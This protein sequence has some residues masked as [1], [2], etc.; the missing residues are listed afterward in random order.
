MELTHR[1]F[2]Y[3]CCH[4]L[5]FASSLGG[6]EAQR[7]TSSVQVDRVPQVTRL[8]FGSCSV[9][10]PFRGTVLLSNQT[11]AAWAIRK[12]DTDCGCLSV[13]ANKPTCAVGQVIQLDVQLAAAN[14][15]A[16]LRRSV[17]IYFEAIDKPLVLN[18]DVSV[19]GPI[20][21]ARTVFDVQSNKQ[22]LEIVGIKTRP[23]I[24]IDRLISG[25][26]G[27][28]VEGEVNQDDDSFRV[29]IQ[30]LHGFGT[31]SDILRVRYEDEK[32]RSLIVE[33]PIELRCVDQIRFLPST[34][35]MQRE[36]GRWVG[37]TRMVLSP[38]SGPIDLKT[39]RCVFA[40][41]DPDLGEGQCE[42]KIQPLSPVLSVVQ[43]TVPDDGQQVMPHFVEI[44]D[45]NGSLLG[46]LHL[47]KLGKT[48]DDD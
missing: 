22:S 34:V 39:I 14:R 3:L 46:T 10:Q 33:V 4:L 19:T 43:V 1:V 23:G 35:W 44:K 30:P 6:G 11:G 24:K 8:F 21:L 36:N 27:F 31:F 26:G 47:S 48:N 20:Q 17:R 40:G 38:E 32:D 29:L 28:L 37:E 45:R 2:L 15:V 41:S 42:A 9:N 13:V 25:R 7:P 18:L 12:I 5:A 16:K